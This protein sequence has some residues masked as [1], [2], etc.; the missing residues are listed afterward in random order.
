VELNYSK[1]LAGGEKQLNHEL[2]LTPQ[3]TQIPLKLLIILICNELLLE[4]SHVGSE[5]IQRHIM[6]AQE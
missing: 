4:I 2:L 3:M 1:V 5:R 6:K